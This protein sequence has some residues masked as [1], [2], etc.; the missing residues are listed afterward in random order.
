MN[1]TNIDYQELENEKKEL[2]IKLSKINKSVEK[3]LKKLIDDGTLKS[4][5]YNGDYHYE[6]SSDYKPNSEW[7]SEVSKLKE[8]LAAERKDSE[9]F[10]ARFIKTYSVFEVCKDCEELRKY[11]NCPMYYDLHC[12]GTGYKGVEKIVDVESLLEKAIDKG[13]VH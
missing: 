10:K 9:Y 1:Q 13:E 3:L 5:F 6:F 12:D 2:E 4:W 7:N 8:D 11:T